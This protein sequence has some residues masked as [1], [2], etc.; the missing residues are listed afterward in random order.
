M[1]DTC[2]QCHTGFFGENCD[3]CPRNPKDHFV[4]GQGG[5]CDDGRDGTGKCVC[6]SPHHDPHAFC[7]I[8][9][10]DHHDENEGEQAFGFTI[11]LLVAFLTTFMLYIFHKMPSLQIVPEAVT[12]ILVGILIGIFFKIIYN[13]GSEM[14]NILSFEPHAFFFFLLPPIMYEAGFT[15]KI[16]P[17]LK[18]IFSVLA[19][20][21]LATMIGA[22]IFSVTFYFLSNQTDFGFDYVQSLEFGCF[23]CAIDPVAVIAIF[24]TLGVTE[25]LFTLVMGECVLNDAVAI[26]LFKTTEDFK[27]NYNPEEEIQ[28][29]MELLTG[30]WRFCFLFFFSLFLGMLCGLIMS[31]IF[32]VLDIDKVAWIEIGLFILGSYFPYILAEG[33]ECSGLLAIL[34]NAIV[35][36]NYCFHSLSPVAGISVEFLIELMCNISEGFVFAYLGISVALMIETSKLSVILVGL[37]SLNASRFLSIWIT[38]GIINIF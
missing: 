3:P 16:K 10:D 9:H 28:I 4:C 32:K 7:E 18:N 19:I 36:R 17:F 29:H 8:H 24:K 25:V 15:L 1:G 12:C 21:V 5:V 31:W 33:F 14:L 34:M 26:A 11:L 22:F 23:I 2:N 20:T 30:A 35:M 6:T 38:M 37:I 27:E 13:K